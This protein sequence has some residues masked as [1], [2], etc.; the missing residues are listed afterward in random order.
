MRHQARKRFGQNFLTDPGIVG[1]IIDAISPGTGQ[2]IVEIGP[3]LAAL[4][5]HLADSGAQLHLVEI[6]R[7]FLELTANV[8]LIRDPAQIIG[9]LLSCLWIS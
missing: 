3:G 1:R 5:G 4:T 2:Q 8:F 6:D 7:A 9:F